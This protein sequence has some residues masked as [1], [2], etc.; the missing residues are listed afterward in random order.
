MASWFGFTLFLKLL[1]PALKRKKI[2]LTLFLLFVIKRKL[3]LQICGAFLPIFD[4]IPYGRN[5]LGG[6]ALSVFPSHFAPII[7]GCSQCFGLCFGADS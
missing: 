6:Q 1:K 7:Q 5:P 4:G 2:L 3:H